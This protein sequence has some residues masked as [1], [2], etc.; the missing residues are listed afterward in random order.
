[1]PLV[2]ETEEALPALIAEHAKAG[3]LVMCLGAG[4]ITSWAAALPDALA[5]LLP[6]EEAS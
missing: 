1:M 5:P 4:S 3:D 2:L 6:K